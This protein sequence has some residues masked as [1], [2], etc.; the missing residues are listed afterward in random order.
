LLTMSHKNL[1]AML[2]YWQQYSTRSQSVRMQQKEK[3]KKGSGLVDI[4][5]PSGERQLFQPSPDLPKSSS[6][7]VATGQSNLKSSYLSE[8][9]IAL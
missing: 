1:E 7:P 2:R 5:F 4:S 9:I 6:K 8:L 3:H